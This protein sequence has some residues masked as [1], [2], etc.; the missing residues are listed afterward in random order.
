MAA[1]RVTVRR[2]GGTQRERH[3]TLEEALRA[4]EAHLDALATTERRGTE[5]ALSRDYEPVRQVAARGELAGPRRLR[6]G[7][8]L[9]GDGSSEAYTGRWRKQLVER[10]AGETAYDALRRALGGGPAG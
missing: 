9:R 2:R 7:V 1:Y 4:L 3:A 5:S 8:D 6:A 10:R